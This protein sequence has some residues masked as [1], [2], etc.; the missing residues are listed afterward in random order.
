M[1]DIINP[2]H[3]WAGSN[4][5]LVLEMVVGGFG[6]AELPYEMVK[7]FAEKDLVE[8]EVTGWPYSMTI[9]VIWS[10]KRKLGQ[11]SSWLLNALTQA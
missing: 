6:W 4:Y 2:T 9:D 7:A 1:F 5:M 11:A 3:Y 10:R 8:L